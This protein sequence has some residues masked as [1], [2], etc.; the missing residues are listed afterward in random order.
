MPTERHCRTCATWV[1]VGREETLER[2]LRQTRAQLREARS[3]LHAALQELALVTGR[4]VELPPGLL[5]DAANEV[6]GR[7]VHVFT[8]RLG[9]ACWMQ[10]VA[11]E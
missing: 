10:V 4:T 6:V 2:E 1:N 11:L 8:E 5:E 3:Q 9:P 7:H